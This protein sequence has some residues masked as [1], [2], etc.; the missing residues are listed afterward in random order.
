MKGLKN[1]NF[2]KLY[3]TDYSA[4]DMQK[5]CCFPCALQY[6]ALRWHFWLSLQ[7]HR[8]PVKMCQ[9]LQVYLSRSD[10]D[11]KRLYKFFVSTFV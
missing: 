4:V 6:A 2:S 8:C 11:S 7:Q 5:M 1:L 3:G 9:L 10:S